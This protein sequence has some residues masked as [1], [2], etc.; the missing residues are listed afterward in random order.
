MEALVNNEI[1]IAFTRE[2]DPQFTPALASELLF[3]EPIVAVFA[4]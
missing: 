3:K 2:L 4:T 1:D